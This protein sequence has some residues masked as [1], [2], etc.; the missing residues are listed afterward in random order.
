MQLRIGQSGPRERIYFLGITLEAIG[1]NN[2]LA[3][4]CFLN[5]ATNFPIT[6]MMVADGRAYSLRRNYWSSFGRRSISIAA[7]LLMGILL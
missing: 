5:T 7:C 4:T 6:Y 2:P 1:P 3:I